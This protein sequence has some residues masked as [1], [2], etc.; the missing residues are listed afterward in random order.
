MNLSPDNRT[1]LETLLQGLNSGV[2]GSQAAPILAATLQAQQAQQ[3]QRNARYQQMAAD[4]AAMAGQGMTQGG[5]S[6]YVDTMTRQSGIPGKF[7]GLID[8]AFQGAEVPTTMAQ[9][10]YSHGLEGPAQNPGLMS[11]LQSPLYTQ[12]PQS[13]AYGMGT[14]QLLSAPQQAQQAAL[15]A[16]PPPPEPPA[17]TDGDQ[18][19]AVNSQINAMKTAGMTPEEIVTAINSDPQV[20]GII[21]DNMTV[22]MQTQP[23]V[24]QHFAPIL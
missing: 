3:E 13:M 2:S 8:S 12:N 1:T 18:M 5:V 17:P 21:M 20:V 4:V 22:F 19:G 9:G 14:N 24:M 6:N 7:Q 15:A 16:M 10:Q 23:E 11:Q